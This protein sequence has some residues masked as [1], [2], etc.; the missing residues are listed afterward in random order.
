MNT[1][2]QKRNLRRSRNTRRKHLRELDEK[3]CINAFGFKLELRSNELP[4]SYVPD[5]SVMDKWSALP[6]APSTRK[7]T[8]PTENARPRPKNRKERRDAYENSPEVRAH[9]AKVE[10]QR[11]KSAQ[12]K[13]IVSHPAHGLYLESDPSIK[14]AECPRCSKRYEILKGS[15]L[16]NEAIQSTRDEDGDWWILDPDNECA[17]CSFSHQSLGWCIITDSVD[18]DSDDED[19]HEKEL[20]EGKK[21]GKTILAELK[22]DGRKIFGY[23]WGLRDLCRCTRC[24]RTFELGKYDLALQQGEQI[25]RL[26]RDPE[27]PIYKPPV[28]RHGV[29]FYY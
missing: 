17:K 19:I 29:S 9:Y 20:K 5:Q 4:R 14:Y 27:E 16:L 2:S 26:L 3:N 10:A 23:N 21:D 1:R 15:P 22:R 7:T 25:R 8:Y 18:S 6:E 24:I 28:T 12:I 11:S 13:R